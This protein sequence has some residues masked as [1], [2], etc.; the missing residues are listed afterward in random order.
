VSAAVIRTA[1]KVARAAPPASTVNEIPIATPWVGLQPPS[2]YACVPDAARTS[3]ITQSTRV[4][5]EAATAA[6]FAT[7]R[8]VT[9]IAIASPAAQ[10]SGTATATGPSSISA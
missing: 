3:R 9:D 10:S 7:R 5:T 4:T 1:T 8:G 2:Q 6:S